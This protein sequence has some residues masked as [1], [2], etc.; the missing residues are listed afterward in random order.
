MTIIFQNYLSHLVEIGGRN[1]LPSKLWGKVHNGAKKRPIKTKKRKNEKPNAHMQHDSVAVTLCQIISEHSV[2]IGAGRGQYIPMAL[3]LHL[4]S[5]HSQ[6]DVT[7]VLVPPHV[8]QHVEGLT[9]VVGESLGYSRGDTGR[10]SG[11]AS[12][13]RTAV[14]R[15]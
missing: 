6:N 14:P 4:S 1:Q 12:R 13:G 10:K 5:G 2:E 7:E 8:G 15:S 11:P 9:G 3:D